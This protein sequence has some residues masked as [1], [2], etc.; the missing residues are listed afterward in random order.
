[1]KSPA[2]DSPS[3]PIALTPKQYDQAK[4]NYAYI[5]N[6]KGEPMALSTA[7]NWLASE[8][9]RTK[10]LQG[11]N[12][13]I[14][15]LPAGEFYIPVDS[16]KV[17]QSPVMQGINFDNIVD[18]VTINLSKK[19]VVTKNEIAILYM[20]D[21]IG[22]EG[23]KRPIYYATTVGS[24]MYMGLSKYFSLCGLAYQITPSVVGE[25]G[26]VN[27][28]VMYDNMMNK[29]LWGGIDNPKVYLDENNRR[30]CRT[31]RLMFV[32]LI[33]ALIEEGET[34]KAKSALDFCMKQIPGKS[35][36]HDYTSI[37]LGQEFLVVGE[38]TQGVDLLSQIADKSIEN[39]N[40][41]FGLSPRMFNS[42]TSEVSHNIA[43]LHNIIKI[44][45]GAGLETEAKEYEEVF[46]GYHK[47][48]SMIRR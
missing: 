10:T 24:D 40:W 48:W 32:R 13:R 1:M 14:D 34:E 47:A 11:Y 18:K 16:A 44:F 25:E 26:T 46:N 39:L 35:V 37:T 38:T 2:Y 7:L 29:F 9:K 4:L 27:T 31:L 20:L 23:W 15:Y 42:V 21:A 30:M 33:E 12:E 45:E 17:A 19:N 22:K 36:P 28:E 6:L 41:F 43:V 5:M 8:D 3:L